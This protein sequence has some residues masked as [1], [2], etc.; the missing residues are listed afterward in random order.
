[1]EAHS[2]AEQSARQNKEVCT[3]ADSVI[4]K[5]VAEQEDGEKHCTECVAEQFD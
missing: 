5:A 4:E 3:A 2:K 1:M